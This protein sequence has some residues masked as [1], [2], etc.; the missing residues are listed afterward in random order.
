[1]TIYLNVSELQSLAETHVFCL[2]RPSIEGVLFVVCAWNV[3]VWQKV[4]GGLKGVKSCISEK[5]EVEL[6][7]SALL[8]SAI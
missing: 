3:A 1:M 6:E 8:A 2:I 7:K 5:V 4:N